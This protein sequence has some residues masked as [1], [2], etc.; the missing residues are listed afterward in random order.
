MIYLKSQKGKKIGILGLGR[1]A[2]A[3]YESVKDYASEIVLIEDDIVALHKFIDSTSNKIPTTVFTDSKLAELDLIA[4][5]PGVPKSHYIFTK[6]LKHNIKIFSDID[7]LFNEHPEKNFIAIT[8]TNGKSTTTSLISHILGSKGRDH[9]CGGNIGVP[10]LSLPDTA[11]GY[12]LELSSFQ[13]EIISSLRTSISILLNITPDHLDRHGTIQNYIR[14]KTKLML[15]PIANKYKIICIDNPIC[16]EIYRSCLAEDLSQGRRLTVAISSFS[17]APGTL[18]IVNDQLNNFIYP[19]QSFS[20]KLPFIKS[21][22]GHHNK[23]NLAAA[24]TACFLSGLSHDEIIDAACRF[25]GLSHRM[26]Y[27]CSIEGIE[28]YNDSKA[29]NADAASMSIASLDNIYWLAGG[30]P[31]EGGIES[32]VPLFHRIK[33]A[34]LFGQSIES[35]SKTLED[36]LPFEIYADISEAFEAAFRDA[37]RDQHIYQNNSAIRNIL[38][39]P[40]ASSFDQF[41]DFEHRGQIFKDLVIQKSASYASK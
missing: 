40:S 37:I 2:R 28:I 41:R 6:A 27:L 24:Y 26:E 22:Q 21:L 23:Q 3:L 4:A 9:P 25:Q 38:L 10:A 18:S 11:H 35:F 16:S 32:L 39:A 29:T 1:S 19:E 15:S 36:R 5:S 17:S 20:K 8:G 13:L 31:K 30:V 7:L 12:V 34:Y 14:A 33:K